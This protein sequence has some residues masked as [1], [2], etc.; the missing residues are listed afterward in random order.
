V[1]EKV[2]QRAVVT[3]T[4]ALNWGGIATEVAVDPA[5]LMVLGGTV[6]VLFALSLGGLV[7]G[8][9]WAPDLVLGLALFD[10]GRSS[11]PRERSASPSPYRSSWPHF[12]LS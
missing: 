2:I 11:W 10:L 4:L 9:A 1:F 3:A 5:V 8:R 6:G 12:F 7:A